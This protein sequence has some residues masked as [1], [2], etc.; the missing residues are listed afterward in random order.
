MRKVSLLPCDENQ[1]LI[2]VDDDQDYTAALNGDFPI[3]PD[4]APDK[5]DEEE[6]DD[7]YW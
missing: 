3:D 5:E 6:D 4:D 1:K 7:A 2:V